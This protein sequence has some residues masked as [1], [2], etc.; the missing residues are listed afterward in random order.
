M[1]DVADTEA[2]V[3]HPDDPGPGAPTGAPLADRL[4]WPAVL[5]ALLPIV[6]ATV[7]A[8]RRGWMPVGDNAYFLIRARDVLTEHHP[9]LGTWTSASQ[10]TGTN[11]NNPGPLFFDVLA[12]PA[13]LGGGT[14]LAIGVAALNGAWVLGIALMARRQGGATAGLV[15]VAAGALL[16]WSMGSQLLFEPWQP[17]S[18]LL[19][20][21]FCAVACWGMANGDLAAPPWA[22]GTASLIVQTHLS[23]AV[24]LAALGVTAVVGLALA[25]RPRWAVSDDRPA[26]R[27]RLGRAAAVTAV[28]LVVAWAQPLVEQVTAPEQGNLVRVATHAGGADETVGPGLGTRIVADTLTVPPFWL[29]PSF[30]DALR[31]RADPADGRSVTSVDPSA[32][33]AA[34]LLV[35]LAAVLAACGWQAFRRSDR[36]GASLVT[37][38]AVTVGAG[39][40]TAWQLPFGNLGIVPHQFRWMWPVGALTAMAVGTSVVRAPRVERR[41]GAV[42]VALAVVVAVTAVANLPYHNVHSGPVGD[43][44]AI[45]VMRRARP[46]MA[47]LE[48][49]GPILVDFDG[50]RFA[51]PYSGPVMAELQRRGIP[52][53]VD[54]PVLVRQLGDSRELDGDAQ[55]LI[56]R[57]GDRADDAPAGAE[58]VVHVTGLDAD[59][60]RELD[61]LEAAI[62]DHIATEGL[63][64]RS[65]A[66]PSDLTRRIVEALPDQGAIDNLFRFRVLVELVVTGQV[67]TPAGWEDRF[68]RYAELQQRSDDG[69]LSLYLAP[70]DR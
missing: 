47:A 15:A 70:S 9:L 25:I 23:Y 4:F 51:E 53:Y 60:Q 33:V 34:A 50:I 42:A 67:D 56:F 22:V 6:V 30:E 45:E 44:R 5:A 1:V 10:S 26:L 36:A 27:R 16:C 55:R 28:V 62:G 12:I 58:R 18:L 46:Q 35:L 38:T 69:S 68:A 32:P 41:G 66:E 7:R 64:L 63:R 3:P 52:F 31:E 37:V 59:D 17:H 29:R 11:F 54:D 20:F 43:E 65:D 8:V 57:D 39:V 49:E 61:D 21:L 24:L 2:T 48:D 40:L 19:P 14:G 13:K